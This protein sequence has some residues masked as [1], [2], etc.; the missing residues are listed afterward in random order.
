LGLLQYPKENQLH[1]HCFNSV[2]QKQILPQNPIHSH[3]IF[4]ST[5]RCRKWSPIFK[6]AI[7]V[8]S[9][10]CSSVFYWLRRVDCQTL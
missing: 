2:H 3:L 1:I 7:F 5:K 9:T 4:T 8:N 6:N 10:N